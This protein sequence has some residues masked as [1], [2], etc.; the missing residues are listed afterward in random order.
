[1]FLVVLRFAENKGRAPALMAAH[2]AWVQRGFDEG[3]FLIVGSLRPDGGGVILARGA[4]PA[5][6][7]ARLDEDPFVQ[8]GVVRADM[9]EFA[10][11]RADE[12]LR[13]L[14]A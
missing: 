6:V 7:Q 3:A 9:V 4:S 5:E 11:P 10:P 12:R 1:M 8:E 2:N 13:F 14:L